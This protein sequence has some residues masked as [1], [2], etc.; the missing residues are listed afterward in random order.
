MKTRISNYALT[1]GLVAGL[2]LTV[3]LPVSA[4]TADDA[5]LDAQIEQA[6]GMGGDAGVATA[7]EFEQEL[8]ERF[9]KCF[10][11]FEAMAPAQREQ[12]IDVYKDCGSLPQVAAV[13]RELTGPAD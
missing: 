2:S 7:A 12:V 4:A 6:L 5:A 13:I 3:A 8:K 10:N 11:R 1:V 9:P